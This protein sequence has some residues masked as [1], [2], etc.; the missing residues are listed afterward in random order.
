MKQVTL[1]KVEPLRAGDEYVVATNGKK[2]VLSAQNCPYFIPTMGQ[3]DDIPNPT[4]NNFEN[5]KKL[6]EGGYRLY[7]LTKTEFEKLSAFTMTFTGGPKVYVE[8]VLEQL[9]IKL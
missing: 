1:I 4:R 8:Q 9:N 6:E 2:L 5:L 3:P 7:A